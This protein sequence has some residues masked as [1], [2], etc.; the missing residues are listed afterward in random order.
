ML[1]FFNINGMA[2]IDRKAIGNDEYRKFNGQNKIL[3]KGLPPIAFSLANPNNEI[4]ASFPN[5]LKAKNKDT[6]IGIK[7]TNN[8]AKK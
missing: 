1:A 7:P 8:P 4:I 3:F 6:I 2:G 5:C